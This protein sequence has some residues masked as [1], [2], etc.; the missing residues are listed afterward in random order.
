MLNQNSKKNNQKGFTL[1]EVVITI[2][3]IGVT[4][5]I[6]YVT[7]QT[8]LVNKG[9]RYKEIAVRIADQKMENL[10]T[11]S[12][13]SLPATGSFTDPL[14]SSIPNGTGAITVTALNAK[15]KDVVVTVSWLNP[16]TGTT[17]QVTLETYITEGGL[18]Q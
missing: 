15:T 3:I 18:G 7:S 12:Y 9:N 17:Q 2:F 16:T 10:R 14:L 11:T 4:L 1:I 5:V 8:V 13:S 6:Y